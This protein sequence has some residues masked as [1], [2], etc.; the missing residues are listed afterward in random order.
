MN[1][2]TRETSS[3]SSLHYESVVTT[4]LSR[5]RCFSCSG[6]S[7]FRFIVV[8]QQLMCWILVVSGPNLRSV[9]GELA[10][11][12]SESDEL[13]FRDASAVCMISVTICEAFPGIEAC[14]MCRIELSDLPLNDGKIRHATEAN[15]AIGPFL[16]CSPFNHI[17]AI[18]SLL[19]SE[20]Y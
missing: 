13:G 20:N 2:T 7:S 4:L 15:S 11:P 5:Y 17:V 8:I 1:S 18:Y 3:Q 14:K 12:I 19:K 16:H 10:R 6:V 9:V